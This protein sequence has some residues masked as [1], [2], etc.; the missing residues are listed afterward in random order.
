V[1]E[2][3]KGQNNDEPIVAAQV[4]NTGDI[5]RL[6][7][8][9]HRDIK[10]FKWDKPEWIMKEIEKGNYFVM[11]QKGLITGAIDMQR[12]EDELYI[13]T[14]AVDS[15]HHDSGL[16]R[17]LILFA[18]GTAEKLG[19]KKLTVESL[20]SYNLQG[21]YQKVGF[22][23]DNPPLGYFQSEPFYRFVMYL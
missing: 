2:I 3:T 21:F 12:S 5:A 13:E 16:G 19:C 22:V 14:I 11:K 15:I 4:E 8:Q 10:N 20:Q 17:R 9:F 23:T 6:N 7:Y 1:E 18:K